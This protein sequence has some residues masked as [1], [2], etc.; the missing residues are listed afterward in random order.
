MRSGPRLPGRVVE[1]GGAPGVE[2]CRVNPWLGLRENLTTE[3][4]IGSPV[5]G[6]AVPN[7]SDGRP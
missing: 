4:M 1:Q 5:F 6:G 3:Q 2:I 7:R